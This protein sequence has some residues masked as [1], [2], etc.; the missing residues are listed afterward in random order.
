MSGEGKVEK[1]RKNNGKDKER[2]EI[3]VKREDKKVK[4][5]KVIMKKKRI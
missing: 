3:K 1:R 4:P 2:E 5:Q